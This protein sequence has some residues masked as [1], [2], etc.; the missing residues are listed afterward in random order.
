MKNNCEE[1]QL[2]V[3]LLHERRNTT[4]RNTARRTNNRKRRGGKTRQTHKKKRVNEDQAN[5]QVSVSSISTPCFCRTPSRE[6]RNQTR[7]TEVG[8]YSTYSYLFI[9]QGSDSAGPTSHPN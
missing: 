5:A 8:T 9:I 3:L 7:Q 6:R 2:L 4:K 1:E